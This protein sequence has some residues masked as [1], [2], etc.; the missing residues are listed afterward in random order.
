[1]LIHFLLFSYFFVF[2]F[3]SYSI[4]SWDNP[5]AYSFSST[6]LSLFPRLHFHIT[7]EVE[8]IHWLVHFLLSS[9]FFFFPF[10][11][12]FDMKLRQSTNWFIFFYPAIS[13]SSSSFSYSI[14][15]WDKPV[16]HS[17]SSTPL[18]LFPRLILISDMK[19]RQASCTFIFFYSAIS[20]F[21]FFIFIFD[22]KL[23]Q[24]SCSF[25]LF[26]RVIFLV[27]YFHF[28]IPY[29]V[30]S[31]DLLVCFQWII[32]L[33]CHSQDSLISMRTFRVSLLTV[34][35]T[36]FHT[37]VWCNDFFSYHPID[38]ERN[39]IFLSPGFF[40]TLTR[41]RFSSISLNSLVF[42]HTIMFEWNFSVELISSF[43]VAYK[44]IS[45]IVA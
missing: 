13:L 25:I 19:L 22:M 1:M 7:Y 4:R 11:F 33:I 14:R 37:Y 9:Y 36:V 42:A 15:S 23:R 44:W 40:L 45:C 8:S 5:L 43:L 20:F 31:V 34:R 18:S 41:S 28:P 16:A 17:M 12:I 29:E 6:Q 2:A 35:M 10:F 3:F 30:E 32:E 26:Y 39:R 21:L 24:F 38:Q 27:R